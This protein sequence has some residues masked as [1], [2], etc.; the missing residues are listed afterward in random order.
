[1]KGRKK[2]KERKVV[3]KA[4]V[5]GKMEP[6][7]C[8][9]GC[10]LERNLSYRDAYRKNPKESKEIQKQFGKL[11]EKGWVRENMS[12][13]AMPKKDGTWRMLVYMVGLSCHLNTFI[14]LMY[15]V[16]RSLIDKCLVVCFDDI[17]IHTTC[18]NDN[19]L[20]VRNVLE[21]LRKETDKFMESP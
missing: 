5:G 9:I 11:I 6:K 20:H 19:L 10:T 1:M 15:H 18:L 14:R 12:P 16:L 3:R 17:L 8:L 21:I 4:T 13:C 7:K 2:K